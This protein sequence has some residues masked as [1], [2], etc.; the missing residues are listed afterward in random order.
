MVKIQDMPESDMKALLLKQDFGHLGVAR[1]NRPYVVPMLYAYD[2]ESLFFFTT[3]G[4]K[5]EYLD[6]NHEVCLQVEAI[7]DKENWQSVMVTGT[8]E[9]L[10]DEADIAIAMEL[11]TKRNPHLTPALN[12]TQVDAWGR[13]SVV[14]V[15][16]IRPR[17]ID[18]R[19]TVEGEK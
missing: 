1:D 3:L 12:L 6:Q 19:R 10:T 9:H 7:E 18:G 4:T 17:L 2:H 13:A 11:I 14:A 16:R 5:T 8:A 15:Y